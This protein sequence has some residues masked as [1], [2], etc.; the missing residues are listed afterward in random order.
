MH[1][2]VF[3]ENIDKFDLFIYHE[4]DI[5]VQTQHLLAFTAATKQLYE[6]L[7]IDGLKNYLVGKAAFYRHFELL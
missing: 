6:T 5:V 4:D 1:R 2:R 3:A 7:G